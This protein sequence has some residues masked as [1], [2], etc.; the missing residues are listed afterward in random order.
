VTQSTPPTDRPL[1]SRILAPSTR[2]DSASDESSG[3]TLTRD[4]TPF[5][6]AVLTP[7]SQPNW[8]GLPPAPP[9]YELLGRLGSGGMGAVYLAREHA[10]ERTV[11]MKFLNRPG[12]P[13]A[14]ERFLVEVRAL[15]QLNHPNIVRVLAVDTYR[16][17]PY[18]TMEYAAGGSLTDRVAE[19]GP[20]PPTEAARLIATVA[21]AVHAANAAGIV[22]RDLKPSNILLAVESGQQAVDSADGRAAVSEVPTADCPLSTLTP[23]VSDFGLA[24]RLDRDDGV[25]QGSGAMGTP[26]FMPPE[27]TGRGR[28]EVGGHSDVYGLGATLYHLLTGRPPFLGES[29][30]VIARVQSEPPERPRSLRPDIPAELEGI[31][32]KCLEKEPAKRYAT[33]AALADDLDRFLAGQAPVAPVLSW[34]R[35]VWWAAARQRRRIAAG[36]V[37]ALLVAGAFGLAR[38]L[39]P[40]PPA[41]SGPESDPSERMRQELDAIRRKLAVGEQVTLVGSDDMPRWFNWRMAASTLGPAPDVKGSCYFQTQ[42]MSLLDLL[43]EPGIPRYQLSAEIRHMAGNG[44]IQDAQDGSDQVGLYFG[45]ADGRAGNL[46]FHTLFAATFKD[47]QPQ[48][49]PPGIRPMQRQAEFGS[50]LLVERS[51]WLPGLFPRNEGIRPFE[52]VTLRPGKWRQLVIDV[53]PEE[54]LVRWRNDKEELEPFDRIDQQPGGWTGAEAQALYAGLKTGLAAAAR[55]AVPAVAVAPWRPEGGAI[56]ILARQSTVA[57]RN[58]VIDPR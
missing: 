40:V 52:P 16:A 6:D 15:A 34:R 2:S 42:T 3:S 49:P 23:K 53:S 21:R 29:H 14:L 1:T 13:S 27:Q 17:D 32:V 47:Y 39:A 46:R 20:L 10:T 9:G 33:T 24:K 51:E 25:T 55:P 8:S 5:P 56:G 22:H 43:P 58:V 57:F 18:F 37:V 36:L 50:L 12:E 41:R 44:P 38:I 4:P 11:A 48:L 30:E 28:G 19:S 45:A 54:V 31:V 7:H 26:N 35:R